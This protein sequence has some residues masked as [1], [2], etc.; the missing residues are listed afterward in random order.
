MRAESRKGSGAWV[1]TEKRADVGAST[2]TSAGDSEVKG[3]T[4]GTHLMMLLR[5]TRSFVSII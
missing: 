4:D 1:V 2:V 3:S 5:V